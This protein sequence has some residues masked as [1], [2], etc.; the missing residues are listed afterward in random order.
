MNPSHQT[1]RN[2]PGTRFTP[3]LAILLLL[4]GCVVD[5]T[6][7]PDH[8]QPFSVDTFISQQVGH[9]VTSEQLLYAPIITNDNSV[10]FIGSYELG[11]MLH[12]LLRLAAGSTTTP[13]NLTTSRRVYY[14]SAIDQQITD[15][16]HNDLAT[17]N[18]NIVVI[19]DGTAIQLD[20]FTQLI[21]QHNATPVIQMIWDD[22]RDTGRDNLASFRQQVETDAA[23]LRQYQQRTGTR[24]SPFALILYDLTVNP[25]NIP[26]L[27]LRPDYLFREASLRQSDLAQV[28]AVASL[29]TTLTGLPPHNLNTWDPFDAD[30]VHAIHD[31]VWDIH[32]DWA[33]G[34]YHIAPLPNPPATASTT[35]QPADNTAPQ[36]PGLLDDG[37]RILFIG[38]SYTAN[39]PHGL[40]ARLEKLTAHAAQPFTIQTTP[41]IY[42]GTP[43]S[44]MLT[45]DSVT[46][47]NSDRF[48]TVVFTSGDDASM[49]QF[50]ETIR[51]AGKQ[52]VIHMTWARN[53]SLNNND[54][55]AYRT[56]TQQLAQRL[57]TLENETGVAVSP[58]GLIYYDL[59]A[60]PPATNSLNLTAPLR[61]DFPYIN[62]NI[63]QNELGALINA[64]T[65][66][67][68]L[69]GK[70]PVGLP[71]DEPYPPKL[72]HDIQQRV[73][74][75]VQQWKAGDIEPQPLP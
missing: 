5:R 22:L 28:V 30:L 75:V 23:T 8:Q 55:N 61:T 56:E 32:L 41:R 74:Q 66:Y 54:L 34:S 2:S 26:H 60:N 57:K 24:I 68:T 31:R 49:Q 15:D 42:W 45:D 35:N 25:P 4:T 33:Q 40:G 59:I 43:L 58:C 12:N 18:H 46:D 20:Q 36:W 63:H 44:R 10:H 65:M 39:G 13:L 29:Y 21:Q 71:V 19:G 51:Q 7:T 50:A 52:P 37:D 73:W 11:D 27:Q 47:I 69:T 9:T 53:P 70:S 14:G 1:K 72:I 62:Q 6:A 16:T 3:L 48:D 67:A 64:F 17:G 38:N